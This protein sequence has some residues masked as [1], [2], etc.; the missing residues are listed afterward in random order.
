MTV[1]DLIEKLKTE[2][3]IPGVRVTKPVELFVNVDENGNLCEVSGN[4]ITL[5]VDLNQCKNRCIA[6][7]GVGKRS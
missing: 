3:C 5:T 2:I 4:K 6:T 1:R 7:A